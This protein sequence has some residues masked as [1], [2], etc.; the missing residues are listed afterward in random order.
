M[1]RA[2][3]EFLTSG[4]SS[5]DATFTAFQADVS[6]ERPREIPWPALTKLSPG[7]LKM[8][9][10]NLMNEWEKTTTHSTMID[11]TAATYPSKTQKAE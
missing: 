9:A 1:P 5:L 11:L 7:N 4:T 3:N 2:G 10:S 6:I 8:T